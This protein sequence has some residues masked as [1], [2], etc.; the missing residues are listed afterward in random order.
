MIEMQVHRILSSQGHTFVVLADARVER[1]LPIAIGPYEANA[2]AMELQ[3][4]KFRRPL[5]HDLFVA[6]LEAVGHTV[7]RVE[8]TRLEEGTFYGL[9]YVVDGSRV[10]PV[11]A[12]PSDAIA[13]AV[14]VD[15]PILV[16]ED[17]LAEA[18]IDASQ[19]DESEEEARFRELM[20]GIG[21]GEDSEDA[22]PEEQDV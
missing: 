6:T 16:A 8:I 5:T 17:V 21:L 3:G 1:L 4:E 18:G 22:G 14:R 12:R 7:C 9:L 20:S 13:L 19:D 11:D 2:I 15:A 10:V